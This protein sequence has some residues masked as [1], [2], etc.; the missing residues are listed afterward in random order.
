MSL[1]VIKYFSSTMLSI[2]ENT[3]IYMPA[4]YM[5]GQSKNFEPRFF[6]FSA[7]ASFRLCRVSPVT[8]LL[9]HL[10]PRPV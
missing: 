2:D 10:P 1:V 8:L 3:V 5:S 9:S 4:V 7:V 6:S